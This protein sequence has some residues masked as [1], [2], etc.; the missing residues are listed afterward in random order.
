MSY[1]LIAGMWLDGSAWSEVVPRLEE[2]GHEAVALTLPGQGDGAATATLD[3]Q[4][5]AV[6][7]AVDRAREPV[8]V[9]GHSAASTLAWMAAD[10]RPDR[11]ARVV[12]IGG[13]PSSPGDLYADFFEPVDGMMHFPGWEPFAGPDSDDLDEA[14]R[15]R[16]EAATI[17][18]PQSVTRGVVQLGDERRF[19]VPVT[20]VCPEFSPDDARAWVASGDVPELARARHVDYVDLATGHWPM[21]SNPAALADVLAAVP[22]PLP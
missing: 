14:M 21:F 13:F 6:V 7:A 10:S 8:V 15:K 16:L 1:V 22:Q 5:A 2:L 19:D 17:P 9:V 3:D 4:R 11:V 12:L 20:L 18:V